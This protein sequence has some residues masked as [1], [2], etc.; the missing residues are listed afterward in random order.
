MTN[1]KGIN[2][3]ENAGFLVTIYSNYMVY[4]ESCQCPGGTA[5]NGSV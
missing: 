4:V 1:M 2:T 3:A 5:C